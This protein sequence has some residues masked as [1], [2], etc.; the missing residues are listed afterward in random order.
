MYAGHTL[1]LNL[2]NLKAIYYKNVL[3]LLNKSHFNLLCA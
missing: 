2:D 3:S 1:G